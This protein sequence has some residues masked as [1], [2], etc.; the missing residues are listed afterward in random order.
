LGGAQGGLREGVQVV[1]GLDAEELY[2]A[3]ESAEVV[4]DHDFVEGQIVFDEGFLLDD[5]HSA[6]GG[7]ERGE[8]I[9]FSQVDGQFDELL[10]EFSDGLMGIVVEGLLEG[11]GDVGVDEVDGRGCDILCVSE[12]YYIFVRNIF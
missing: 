6:A 3:I 1:H 9:V 5:D 7:V 8:D 10:V 2:G 12:V 4:G 11:D